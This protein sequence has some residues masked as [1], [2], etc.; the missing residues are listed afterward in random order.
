MSFKCYSNSAVG[1]E[2]EIVSF[3]CHSK[4]TVGEEEQKPLTF[5]CLSNST[6]EQEEEHL[7]LKCHSNATVGKEEEQPAVS[8]KCPDC[9]I[10]FDTKAKHK[11]HRLKLHG[12]WQGGFRYAYNIIYVTGLAWLSDQNVH[13]NE[14]FD[15]ALQTQRR[16][17]KLDTP[18][19]GVCVFSS[20]KIILP[21]L[22]LLAGG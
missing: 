11:Y 22:A 9:Q 6:A 16:S 7:S 20:V 2:E 3:K 1:E 12:K 19:L 15:S 8:F 14:P 13:V 4:S 10:I 17:C 18:M 5:K 21:L